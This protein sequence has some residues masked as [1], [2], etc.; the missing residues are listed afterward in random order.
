VDLLGDALLLDSKYPAH[1]AGLTKDAVAAIH[2]RVLT[3]HRTEMTTE[4]SV[5]TVKKVYTMLR[6]AWRFGLARELIP[7]ERAYVIG[8]VRV[9]ARRKDEPKAEQVTWTV[10]QDSRF[11]DW[12]VEHRPDSWV[13]L[14]FVA[15][16]G[17]RVS[18]NLGLR[19]ADVDFENCRATLRWYVKYHGKPGERVLVE[20]FGKTSGGHQIVLDSRTMEVLKTEKARQSQLRL[21]RPDRHVCETAGRDCSLPGYHDRGLVFPQRDGNY[22]NPNKFLNLFQDAIRAFNRDHH[23]DPLPVITERQPEESAARH[24]YPVI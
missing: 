5:S 17:N 8:E 4:L 19:W 14:Y 11:F 16:S 22:R 12:A 24:R 7:R 1:C 23:D 9:P 6:S 10:V 13:A 20:S 15:T 21:A 18:A 3:Q 2:R